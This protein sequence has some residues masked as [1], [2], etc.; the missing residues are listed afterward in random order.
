MRSSSKLGQGAKRTGNH[1]AATFPVY[2]SRDAMG[3]ITSWAR[4][5]RAILGEGRPGNPASRS[6]MRCPATPGRAPRR[7]GRWLAGEP[8]LGLEMFLLAARTPRSFARPWGAIF[9]FLRLGP[10]TAFQFRVSRI[11]CLGREGQKV[12]AG[13]LVGQKRSAI[14]SDGSAAAVENTAQ[15]PSLRSGQG[16][17]VIIRH[18]L[19]LVSKG[20]KM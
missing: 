18:R 17:A 5:L 15:Q 11:S 10:P 12:P 9:A 7:V 2:S 8:E 4:T 20:C 16:V 3:R 6:W 1:P 13:I 19:V 14:R